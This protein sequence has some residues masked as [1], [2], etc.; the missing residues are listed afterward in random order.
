MTGFTDYL[1]SLH[2]PPPY[3]S[4]F[5]VFLRVDIIQGGITIPLGI[6]EEWLSS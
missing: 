5:C 6:C 2:Q 3:N 4:Q 1:T